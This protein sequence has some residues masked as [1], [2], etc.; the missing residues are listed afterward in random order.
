M[1]KRN[2]TIL[3]RRNGEDGDCEE[4]ESREE[5]PASEKAQEESDVVMNDWLGRKLLSPLP[6]E[7]LQ[8]TY[9]FHS[10]G[11]PELQ[12]R[13]L[14]PPESCL[15]RTLFPVNFPLGPIRIDLRRR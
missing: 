1:H 2:L 14:I 9:Y 3:T 12:P 5:D 10:C 6:L 11:I 13:P 4:N 7:V 8:M 15:A